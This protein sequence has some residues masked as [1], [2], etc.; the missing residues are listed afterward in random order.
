MT[1]ITPS[2]NN[3]YTYYVNDGIISRFSPQ[4]KKFEVRHF[5]T[6]VWNPTSDSRLI[7]K[8]LQNKGIIAQEEVESLFLKLQRK[9][10]Q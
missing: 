2:G 5:K 8:M 4:E 9:A 3:S 10:N 6:C 7:G 1:S